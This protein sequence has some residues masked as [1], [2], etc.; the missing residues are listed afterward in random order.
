MNRSAARAAPLILFLIVTASFWKLLTKQYTWMDHPDMAYQVL[1]WYQF[2]A[3]SWHRGEF[4][5]WDP[6]VWGG[7]PLIGQLQPGAAYPPNWLLFL[8]PLKDG[9]IQ[10]LWFHLYFILTHCF[11]ALFCYWLCRDLGR[12]V[13]A[14]VFAGFAFALGGTVGSI[15][16]PQMLNGAIWIPLVLL[17]YL[18]SV[19]GPG[20]LR[21]AAFSG[22]FLGIKFPHLPD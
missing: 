4:P 9:H 11:A 1:P 15:E 10:P 20:D 16:W 13:P 8:L 2:E 14:S 12:T 19:R 6:K 22:T 5:L 3:A 7:Q 21:S 17:F 18:R